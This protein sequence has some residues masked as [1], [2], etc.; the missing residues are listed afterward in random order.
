MIFKIPNTL[1]IGAG[2][3]YIV[4]INNNNSLFFRTYVN[5]LIHNNNLKI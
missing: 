2:N 5:I 1:A 3:K 4:N